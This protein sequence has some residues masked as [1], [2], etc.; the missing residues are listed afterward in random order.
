MHSIVKTGKITRLTY[1]KEATLSIVVIL[2][3]DF[4]SKLIIIKRLVRT[5]GKSISH[6]I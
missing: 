6:E 5:I 2:I 4:Q 3:K 1:L